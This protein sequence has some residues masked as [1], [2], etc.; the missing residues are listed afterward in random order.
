M[1]ESSRARDPPRPRP[2]GETPAHGT[3][4]WYT[5]WYTISSCAH[6]AP[7]AAG[8]LVHTYAPLMVHTYAPLMVPPSWCAPRGALDEDAYA[9]TCLGGACIHMPLSWSGSHNSG[10]A[11]GHSHTATQSHSHTG[12]Q[13]H[14]VRA[15][16][17]HMHPQ[18]HM[19][20]CPRRHIRTHAPA[21]TYAHMPTYAHMFPQAHGHICTRR[22]LCSRYLPPML[23][24]SQHPRLGRPYLPPPLPAADVLHVRRPPSSSDV[25]ICIVG[26]PP[27][28]FEDVP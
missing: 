5:S 19:P 25:P 2:R 24:R 4:S 20:T 12:T 13:A 7:R 27:S 26:S 22:H 8:I 28:A 17:A 23:S 18:A 16:Y 15:T 10:A 14:S 3:T 11:H 9:H 1:L 21:G 6:L